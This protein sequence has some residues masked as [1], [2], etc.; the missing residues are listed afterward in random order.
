VLV[1]KTVA[2]ERIL[3]AYRAGER[4]FGENRVQ[5]LLEKKSRLP[6]DIRWHMIGHL[7][8]NKAK[9]VTGAAVLVHSLDRPELARELARQAVKRGV[10]TEC[11]IQVHLTDE[12]TKF[13]LRPADV[14]D[15]VAGLDPG[16]P[17]KVKG[18]MT[19]GPLTE[20]EQAV[21][22]CF[23]RAAALRAELAEKFKV[24]EWGVLSMGMS[25][26]WRIAVEEGATMLR[27]G[28]AVF[29]PRPAA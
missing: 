22:D 12:E 5:E 15:F 3:E 25:G 24:W 10:V 9:D 2:P 4:D 28:S 19:I 18:L 1:T 14:S 20:N 21:R 6:A 16:G 23:R 17:L 13:G 27:I 26:D 8:T 7:Q 11:L 29:G